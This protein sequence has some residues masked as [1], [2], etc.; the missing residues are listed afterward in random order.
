[1]KFSFGQSG[2]VFV[3]I[4]LRPYRGFRVM[5]I[6]ELYCICFS[7][8]EVTL[9]KAAFFL[10]YYGLLRVSEIVLTHPKQADRALLF[11]DIHIEDGAKALLVTIRISKT[12]QSGPPLNCV[13]QLVTISISVEFQQ[14]RNT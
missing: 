6:L 9:F 13:F 7:S 5:D 3:H 1:M 10:A 8:S 14:S 11:S 2:L 4:A 12:N